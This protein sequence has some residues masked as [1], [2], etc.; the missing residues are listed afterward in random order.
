MK[1]N[2]ILT[3]EKLESDETFKISRFK[4]KIKKTRPHKHGGYYELIFLNQ[5]E[6]FHWIEEESYLVCPPDLYFM[7][8]DQLHCWQFT[9]IPKGYVVLFKEAFLDPLSEAPL[10]RLISQLNAV[11]RVKL[12]GIIDLNPVFETIFEVYKNETPYTTDIILGYLR[13]LF[14]MILK[15]SPAQST[16][17]MEPIQSPYDRFIHLIQK[18]CPHIHQ[19]REYAGLLNI[20]PQNLNALCKKQNGSSARDHISRQML[21]EAKRNIL[22]TDKSINELADHLRF[23]DASYFVK[24]FKKHTGETPFQFREKYFEGENSAK[25]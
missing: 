2:E 24:F 7:K 17:Q 10:I 5:G 6:G 12:D 16:K 3:K 18:H 4:E 22:H 13:S 8:P 23:N 11:N 1:P 19:V 9:S 25:T 20:S 15:F 14:A 21:I